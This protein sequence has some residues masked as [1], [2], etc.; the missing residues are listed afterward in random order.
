[1]AIKDEVELLRGVPAFRELSVSRMK[2][3]AFSCESVTFEPETTII[4]QGEEG[5]HVFVILSGEA[6]V[7]IGSGD[8]QRFIRKVGVNDF[9]GE[10]AVTG[11][12]LRSAT[13]LARSKVGALQINAEL[14]ASFI[15]EAPLLAQALGKHGDIVGYEYE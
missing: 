8:D 1:M 9:V 7:L 4:A 15:D 6:D 11:K 5:D 12:R 10:V 2:L 3:L 13:V 14:L